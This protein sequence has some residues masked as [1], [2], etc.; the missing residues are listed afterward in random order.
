MPAHTSSLTSFSALKGDPDPITRRDGA[1]KTVRLSTHYVLWRGLQIGNQI[2]GSKKHVRPKEE[3]TCTLWRPFY[4]DQLTTP[5]LVCEGD[6]SSAGQTYVQTTA[7]ANS[8]NSNA[9]QQ[10]LQKTATERKKNERKRSLL[11]AGANGSNNQRRSSGAGV[12][13]WHLPITFDISGHVR[14]VYT[15]CSKRQEMP[16]LISVAYAFRTKSP[17]MFQFSLCRLSSSVNGENAVL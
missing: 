11:T 17:L 15:D 1:S 2:P 12:C 3:S 16:E 4:G 9:R 8:Q 6:I 7:S 5:L 14:K 13:H 10:M